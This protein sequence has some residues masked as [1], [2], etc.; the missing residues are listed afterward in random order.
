MEDRTLLSDPTDD[1]PDQLAGAPSLDLATH[2]LA[3]RRGVL[4]TPADVDVFRFDLEITGRLT[5]TVRAP[6]AGTRLTLV[7][8]Q[9]Q[10]LVQS[11]GRSPTE[12]D[13]EV[14]PIRPDLDVPLTLQRAPSPVDVLLV[15]DSLQASDRGCRQPRSVR[16]QQGLEGLGEVALAIP[17]SAANVCNAL[18]PAWL[19]APA[20]VS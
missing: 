7:D 10:V 16:S 17:R 2:G 4:E 1:Y 14:D 20:R 15:P 13:V 5:A 12:Q 6:S 19:P 18:S 3:T 8:D 9:G 11:D